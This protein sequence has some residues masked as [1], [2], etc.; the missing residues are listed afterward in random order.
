MA[1]EQETMDIAL[2]TA[3]THVLLAGG[4][5]GRGYPNAILTNTAV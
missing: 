1:A 4:F 3:D 5:H 2:D